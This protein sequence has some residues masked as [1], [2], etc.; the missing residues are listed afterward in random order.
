MDDIRSYQLYLV[1]QRQLSPA[2]INT[3]VTAVQFLYTVTLEM[4]GATS[5]SPE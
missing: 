4:P 1:E 2:S 3:F 5:G